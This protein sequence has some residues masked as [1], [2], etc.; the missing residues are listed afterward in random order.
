[1]HHPRE[2]WGRDER[3]FGPRGFGGFGR[4]F[5]GFGPGQGRG[6]RGFGGG[7]FRVG[8]ML[9]DGDL[10]L[11]VLA[12][13]ESG[14]RHGYDVIKALEEKSS[15]IY[16]PSPGVVYPTL[17]FLEEAGYAT[18]T[19]EGN[20]KVYAITDSGRAYL[21]ENRETVDAVLNGIEKFGQKMAKAR[22]W[23][24]GVGRGRGRGGPD[25]D[26]PGVIDE[27]NEAR[28]ALKDAIA[29]GIEGTEDEQ[30]RIA[31]IL[32]EAASAIRAG[33]PKPA[34]EVDL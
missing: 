19:T 13:L 33:A 31:G 14:P 12:L 7:A 10:R 1:M 22:E 5:G 32:R 15:G 29:D 20:K 16:S 17:T 3:R 6:G 4:G 26:I 23:W 24:E 8:K 25:R 30:R 18:A 27:L 9:A 34:P 21:G 2:D 11:I 28:R